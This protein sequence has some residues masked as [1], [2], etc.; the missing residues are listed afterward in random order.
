MGGQTYPSTYSYNLAGDFKTE[1]YLSGR[2]MTTNYDTAARPLNMNGVQSG[3]T[4]NYVQQ[5]GYYPSGAFYYLQY[6]NNV[7]TQEGFTE[8][9]R[10]VVDGCGAQ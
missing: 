3:T 10:P 1:T 6:G 2:V 7:R 9:L 4:S 5:V 8:S